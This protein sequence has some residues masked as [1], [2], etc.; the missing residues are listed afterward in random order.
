MH[1]CQLVD[2]Q[3][4]TTVAESHR[5]KYGFLGGNQRPMNLEITPQVVEYLDLVLVTFVI[6]EKLRR[7]MLTT[8]A[9][10]SNA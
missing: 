5:K 1:M 4:H 8:I 2:R 3:T 9:V 10:V 7:D 6:V